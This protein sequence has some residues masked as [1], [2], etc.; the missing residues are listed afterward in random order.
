MKT[1]GMKT[2]GSITSFM[3]SKRN[4]HGQASLVDRRGE[5]ARK[6]SLEKKQQIDEEIVAHI[7]KYKPVV[8][9]YKLVHAPKRRYLPCDLSIT[10][11]WKDFSEIHETTV[12]SYEKYRR[13]FET[14]NISFA[15][16]GQDECGTC[17]K[18]KQHKE[19]YNISDTL[20]VHHST[21][22]QSDCSTAQGAE[23]DIEH[24]SCDSCKS[25]KLHHER[26]TVARE[27]YTQ[28]KSKEWPSNTNIY[29]VDMQKVL[30][31]P[32]MAEKNSF[33]VSRLVAFNETFS[34][35]HKAKNICV[36]WHEAITGRNA[37]DV[38]ST[39][40]WVIKNSDACVNEFI[41][42]SDN[43]SALN[44]N[45]VLYS[46]FVLLVNQDWG[47]NTIRM[48]YF[49]PGHSFMRAD[50]VHGQI[51]TQL[52]KQ[53]EV[54][55]FQDLL[56]VIDKSSNQTVSKPLTYE[57]FRGFEDG[58]RQR[59]KKADF[60]I[61]IIPLLEDVRIAEFRKSSRSLFY[62]TSFRQESYL[63]SSFLKKKFFMTLPPKL[64]GNRGINVAKRTKIEEVLCLLARTANQR[65]FKRFMF[66]QC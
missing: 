51:G 2:D 27:E 20:D 24:S 14:L 56:N 45:W 64:S 10:A 42:W 12:V 6:I 46:T 55:D 17:S 36:M 41:F 57:D 50:S 63:E 54:L 58:C 34:P 31:I 44:K 47:P 8:S 59:S 19:E 13:I 28:D 40:F 33:F 4:N 23:H 26:Y 1:L 22:E 16:P 43:C 38:A 11:L 18:F 3:Q 35:L 49:E 39:F 53:K 32:K 52:K 66:N 21:A 30:I 48:K 9:H 61:N 60:G 25:F 29:T 7:E 5:K 15:Q 65:I 37:A 62:K